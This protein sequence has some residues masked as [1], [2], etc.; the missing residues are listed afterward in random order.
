MSVE[1]MLTL[2]YESCF[3][4]IDV[5]TDGMVRGARVLLPNG[6][7]TVEAHDGTHLTIGGAV[8]EAIIRHVEEEMRDEYAIDISRSGGDSIPCFGCGARLD[9]DTVVWARPD[10]TLSTT[11][12]FPYCDGC[13]PNEGATQYHAD[14]PR[15]HG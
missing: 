5:G 8:Y 10:G 6:H 4:V 15:S 7:P 11:D 13:L 1:N 3:V 12:G 14:D 9:E 2:T